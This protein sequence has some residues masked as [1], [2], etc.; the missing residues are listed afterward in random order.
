[1]KSTQLA[2][3][4]AQQLVQQGIRPPPPPKLAKLALAEQQSSKKVH[5]LRDGAVVLYKRKE[6]TVWQVRFR[7]FERK[8]WL[9]FSTKQRDLIYAKRI[10]GDM[11]DRARFK[12][13]LG[14]PQSVK[15]FST[16]AGHEDS[17]VGVSW[18]S[19]SVDT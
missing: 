3:P 17:T 1:V 15:R 18:Q 8:D 14:I 6:S 16:A 13:E 7:L 4:T 2:Y 19:I 11:Y 5:H 12:E 9:S 10:A